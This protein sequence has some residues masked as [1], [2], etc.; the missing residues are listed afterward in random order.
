MEE[1]DI[2]EDEIYNQNNILKY[3]NFKNIILIIISFIV[4]SITVFS[5][6]PVLSFVMLCV[7]SFFNFPLL[8]VFITSLVGISIFNFSIINIL[9]ISVFFVV[10]TLITSII[11]IEGISKRFI[12]LFKLAISLL[13]TMIISIFYTNN[14]DILIYMY[15]FLVIN[16]LYIVFLI[17]MYV[18]LN[19]RKGFVFSS[20]E[21][22]AFII[23]LSFCISSLSGVMIFNLS[24]SNI[25]FI[26]TII[27]FSMKNGITL[28]V[29]SS[30]IVGVIMLI[31]KDISESYLI[32]L[33]VSAAISG[34]FYKFKKIYI[35]LGFILGYVLTSYLTSNFTMYSISI[36]EVLIACFLVLLFPK[37]LEEK[38]TNYFTYNNKLDDNSVLLLQGS[39]VIDKLNVMSDIFDD[40]SINNLSSFDY[41]EETREAITKYLINYVNDNCYNCKN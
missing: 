24:L 1:N 20:E 4:S 13:L 39:N 6:V 36:T 41:I 35:L 37:K 23:L 22:I 26:I 33:I 18:L 17:G 9:N 32:V 29:I 25:L 16:I 3:L 40:L 5:D 15:D 12:V 2:I 8:I 11:N 27:V 19:F 34:L 38:L 30:C 28:G 31:T 21:I 10:F 14:I 7:A